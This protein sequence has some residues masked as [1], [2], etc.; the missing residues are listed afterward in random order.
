MSAIFRRSNCGLYLSA[1]RA[2]QRDRKGVQMGQGTRSADRENERKN[3]A[4][5]GEH[6]AFGQHL[7]NQTTTPCSQR[8][9]DGNLLL[10]YRRPRE[11]QI[12]EIG[13]NNQHHH[14]DSACEHE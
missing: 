12:G 10:T 14:T 11:Q 5:A 4:A 7:P 2:K 1:R 6:D 8:G 3:S 13:T 9:S